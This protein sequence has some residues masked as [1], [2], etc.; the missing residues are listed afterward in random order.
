MSGEEFFQINSSTPMEGGYSFYTNTTGTTS[1]SANSFVSAWDAE[2]QA[3]QKGNLSQKSSSKQTQNSQTGAKLHSEWQPV[4]KAGA[5]EKQKN[6]KSDPNISLKFFNGVASAA[7]N[8]NCKSEDLAAA[9]FLESHFDPKAK[10]GGATGLIQMDKESFDS[11]PNRKCTYTQYCKLPREKQLQYA[12]KYLQMRIDEKGLTGKHLTGGQLYTLIRRP[13]S[14][15]KKS[16]VEKYQ[17][18]IDKIKKVPLR[19]QK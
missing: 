6:F 7:K 11:I 8:L 12:E 3:R 18:L 5:K 19:Y 10:N 2:K 16:D 14:I 15:T 4:L 17:R 13:E 1:T 9:M